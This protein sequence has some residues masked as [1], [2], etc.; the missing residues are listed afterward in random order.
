[1]TPRPLGIYETVL[2]A[3]DVAA[4]A[5]FYEHLLGL[6]PL[7][8]LG[9]L[10]AAFRLSDGGMLLIFDP[11]MSATP[12]RPIPSHGATGQ[13]HVAFAVGAGG[14]DA[15]AAEL[16]RR[17]VAIESEVEWPEGGRSLYIRDPAGNSVE[18]IEGEAWPLDRS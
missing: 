5:A 4:A 8:G 10:G 14:V 2:Y 15:F 3:S 6:R 17:G 7:P 11:E 16:R 1:V 18:L 9:D 13:G 12:G